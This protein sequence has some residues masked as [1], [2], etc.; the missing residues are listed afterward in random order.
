MPAKSILIIEPDDG[1][2]RELKAVFGRLGYAVETAVDGKEGLQ[3]C[4]AGGYD[5]VVAEVLL[6]GVN[7]LNVC[8][9]L[10]EQPGTAPRVIVVSKIYQSRA[11]EYDAIN[12]YKA[13]AYFARPFPLVRLIEKIHALIGAPS[14]LERPAAPAWKGEAA[15]PAPSR[16]ASGP[17]PAPNDEWSRLLEPEEPAAPG[18]DKLIEPEVALL[19]SPPP[20]DAGAFTP[21]MLGRMLAKL[22]RERIDGLLELKRA[23]EVKHVYLV[24]G[25][26]VFVKSSNPDESLGRMLVAEQAITEEQYR[27][28]I[29]EMNATK[30]KFGTIVAARGYMSSDS[31]Y[32]HLVNQ[33]RLKI[34]RCFAWDHGEY[35]LD[36]GARYAPEATTFE[37]DPCAVVLEGYRRCIDAGPME[38]DYERDKTRF[39]FPGD[40]RIAAEARQHLNAAERT[41]LAAADGKQRLRDVVGGSPLGLMAALRIVSA[42]VCLGAARLAPVEKQPELS[43]YE[44]ESAPNPDPPESEPRAAERF[45]ELKSLFVRMDDLNAFELLGTTPNADV[46]QVRAAFAALETKFHPDSFAANT[47]ERLQHIAAIVIRRLASARD[48]LIDPVRRQEY[49]RRT[50]LETGKGGGRGAKETAAPPPP[51]APQPS[52]PPAAPPADAAPPPEP[53]T[54]RTTEEKERE[55]QRLFQEGQF[56]LSQKRYPLAVER[57]GQA[58]ALAPKNAEYQIKLATAMF[59]Q[60][61]EPGLTWDDVERAAKRAAATGGENVDL[62]LLIGR[63]KTRR[64]DLD[65]ALRYFQKALQLEPKNQECRREVRYAEQRLKSGEKKKTIFG[66]GRLR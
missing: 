22:G 6:S 33:T 46:D 63:A 24:N 10:K 12:R 4:A 15:R 23:D 44:V 36:R 25:K 7:G 61:D 45:R 52:G 17:A 26:P 53:G 54:E 29:E 49:L 56:A 55:A 27:N 3:K 37:S 64:G 8:K 39:L 40:P 50:G 57:L 38:Q 59:K 21:A 13:D 28:G 30:K 5:L 65:K 34:A 2:R 18:A 1:E 20:P 41:L 58:V 51:T 62:L 47:P 9:Q 14:T 60:L 32:Y 19:E 66:M 43:P 42:L 48:M 35:R 11:M 16:A 31:L